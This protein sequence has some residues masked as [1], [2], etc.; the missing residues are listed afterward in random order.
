[1][2]NEFQGSSWLCFVIMVASR[3]GG[4]GGTRRNGVEQKRQRDS[5]AVSEQSKR[6]RVDASHQKENGTQHV[7]AQTRRTRMQM[8]VSGGQKDDVEASENKFDLVSLIEKAGACMNLPAIERVLEDTWPSSRGN[9]QN[10]QHLKEAYRALD[11]GYYSTRKLA[12]P[13]MAMMLWL[14]S[15]K[16]SEDA[17][18]DSACAVRNAQ[19]PSQLEDL[20]KRR[21]NKTIDGKAVLD[22]YLL[23]PVHVKPQPKQLPPEDVADKAKKDLLKKYSDEFIQL[24]SIGRLVMGLKPGEKITFAKL[25]STQFLVNQELMF[26][27]GSNDSVKEAI[28]DDL[29]SG[30]ICRCKGCSKAPNSRPMKP[31]DFLSHLNT[32]ATQAMVY[33]KLK[34]FDQTLNQ[35]SKLLSSDKLRDLMVD[36]YPDHCHKCKIG[37]ELLCCDGCTTAWHVKCTEMKDMPG[38]DVPFLCS[39][40]EKSAKNVKSG[41]VKDRRQLQR[42]RNKTSQSQSKKKGRKSQG[43]YRQSTGGRLRMMAP[44]RHGR[45]T[46]NLN[47][48]KR[49]FQGEQGGL[50]SGMR[51]FYR[52]RGVEILGGYIVINPSGLSG[53]R[54]DHCDKI[55]SC[56]Q[57]ESH[58]GHAQRRQPY[59]HIHVVEEGVNLK[60]IAAR[61]PDMSD[62]KGG[63]EVHDI[64]SDLDALTGGCT[65]C[66]EPDFQKGDFGSRTIMICDQCEREY[67]VG[68]LEEHGL[69][70]LESLPEGDWFC[71]DKCGR[72]H[73]HFKSL[74]D[75]GDMNAD[76]LLDGLETSNVEINVPEQIVK[77]EDQMNGKRR[78]SRTC[79]IAPKP[80]VRD[81]PYKLDIE[82]YTWCVLNGS[83]GS[84]ETTIAI[85]EAKKILEE[86]FDPIMDLSTN[87]DLLPLM[88]HAEQHGEWD[89][90]G[91]HT[92]L[93][94]YM[95]TP[96]V[97]AIVRVFGPQMAE[98]PLIATL[99]SQRRKGHAKVLVDL[100][101]KHLS[102][103]GIHKL[104][105]PAAHETVG[106][107]KGGFQFEDMPHEDVR[108][109]KH[110]LKVL[111]FPGTEMLWKTIDSTSPATGHHVLKPILTEQEENELIHVARSMV[112]QIEKEFDLIAKTKVRLTLKTCSASNMIKVEFRIEQPE[113]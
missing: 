102:F 50:R 66:R 16:V 55:I 11:L 26:K 6:A 31:K 29:G 40:C 24:A 63:E 92:L 32:N 78:S 113:S 22:K 105:L 91:V 36:V 93:L 77:E 94:K 19:L 98:L 96:V 46:R 14:L 47:R 17:T 48:N 28:V 30:I 99:K 58:A 69:G 80:T 8:K 86:S 18:Y 73:G 67:H 85:T 34:K 72:I 83:D 3:R 65:F 38:D 61:L 88:I 1:M 42:I 109:A 106:A 107:W 81:S 112:N 20:I 43:G 5:G 51:V 110:Q 13:K 103:A 56:S 9:N 54:C 100:F 60:K 97:A 87:T 15:G 44:E 101:Q 2:L 33:L 64:Y 74:V 10:V 21:G 95:D 39:L 68:C 84:D 82:G 49:L 4:K 25:F 41:S 23:Q 79:V 7:G 27:A 70:K 62:G 53:I 108:L 35:L 12:V 104:V 90:R 89:Y 37:G 45:P 111:V 59:E 57:F 76:I 75:R 52:A 71:D